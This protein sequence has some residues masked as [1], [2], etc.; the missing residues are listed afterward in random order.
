MPMR[1]HYD[2][3]Y[4]GLCVCN[5]CIACERVVQGKGEID[6][7]WLLGEDHPDFPDLVPSSTPTK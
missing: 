2:Y 7:W 6:T 5:A 3:C 1:L 4:F